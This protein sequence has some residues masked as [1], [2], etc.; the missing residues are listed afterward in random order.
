MEK[1]ERVVNMMLERAA[2]DLWQRRATQGR[3]KLS[4]E[5]IFF[6]SLNLLHEVWLAAKARNYT[7][8]ACGRVHNSAA[9][10]A[11][12]LY[13]KWLLR[14]RSSGCEALRHRAPPSLPTV[15]TGWG[16]EGYAFSLQWGEESAGRS[17]MSASDSSATGLI[18]NKV[19]C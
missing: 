8:P 14:Q 3:A 6:F 4:R 1:P 2:W 18:C 7:I 11:S 16:E 13:R 19:R 17:I 15:T 12:I 9:V 10:R 5:K